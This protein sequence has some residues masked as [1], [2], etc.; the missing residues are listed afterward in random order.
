[1]S[2]KRTVPEDLIKVA[3]ERL[4]KGLAPP[5]EIYDVQN[6]DRIDWGNV[7][8]WARSIDPELFEGCAHEG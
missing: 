5:R 8:D 1:M 7:P 6:R 4:S 2:R 3:K